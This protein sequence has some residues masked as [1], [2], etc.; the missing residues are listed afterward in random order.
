MVIVLSEK[1]SI[2]W[3]TLA[4]GS[5]S[6]FRT[7]EVARHAPRSEPESTAPASSAARTVARSATR[8][9]PATN[10]DK[11]QRRAIHGVLLHRPAGPR[12]PPHM[13]GQRPKKAFLIRSSKFSL[14]GASDLR[15]ASSPVSMRKGPPSICTFTRY[16]S[17]GSEGTRHEYRQ[18]KPQPY[19]KVPF[20]TTSPFGL[21]MVNSGFG[22]R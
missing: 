8:Y 5:G 11:T 9:T 16:S 12:E 7:M 22:G 3:R 21:V 13:E 19:S 1:T 15:R 10:S 6:P 2:S 14:A 20:S 17:A 4:S 18:V